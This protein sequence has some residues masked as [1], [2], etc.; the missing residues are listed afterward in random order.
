[1]AVGQLPWAQ[2]CQLATAWSSTLRHFSNMH[3]L[4]QGADADH[5]SGETPH[6]G[7]LWQVN[8]IRLA[9]ATDPQVY[10]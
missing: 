4:T 10:T 2:L 5:T 6:H 9:S 8:A 3:N 1:M 7:S